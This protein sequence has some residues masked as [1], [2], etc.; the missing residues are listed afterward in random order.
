MYQEIL[1]Q[2][3]ITVVIVLSCIVV[4]L[5][6]IF[7]ITGRLTRSIGTVVAAMNAAAGG[8]LSARVEP[9]RTM[10][11]EIE[12][13]AANFNSMIEKIQGLIHEVEAASMKQKDAEIAAL[14]A[15]VNPHFL[16][17]TLDTINWMAIDQNEYEISN[18][19]GALAEIL[20][21]GI[22]NSN[23]IVEI[24]REVE[25]LNH[26]VSLQQTRLKDTFDFRL[27]VDPS[28][29]DCH[30]H[31]LLFQPFIEN[32]ILHGF[33]GIDT[34]H[35]LSVSIGREGD[36]VSVTIADNGRGMDEMIIREIER[37][38][39]PN[40]AR[41]GHIGMC[42]AIGRI[43]MYYGADASVDIESALGKGTRVSIYFPAS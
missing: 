33:R 12:E 6:I 20:R 38:T 36:R 19:I 9:D 26:Y 8:E 34:K 7:V 16:Y 14:E 11:L 41:K 3:K 32:S 2:Q 35:E 22:D 17:N 31:K 42:N 29:L 15:Q 23:E 43:K 21:Y 18:A 27:D 4:L 24:R 40:E 39:Y 37:G 10:P 5:A 28:A 30:L 13:I 1:N 25:W